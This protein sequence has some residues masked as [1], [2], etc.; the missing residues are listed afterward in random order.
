VAETKSGVHISVL[1]GVGIY[2]HAFED[3]AWFL[4][5]LLN[6]GEGLCHRSIQQII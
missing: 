1:H 6:S 2:R 3:Y 5:W 4:G